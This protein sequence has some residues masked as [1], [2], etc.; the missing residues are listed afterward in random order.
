MKAQIS[1]WMLSVGSIV[2]ICSNLQAGTVT[3][4][5]GTNSFQMEFVTIGNP[6]NAADTTG[7]PNPVGSVGYIYEM[8][9]YEVSE[10]M[11]TKYNAEFG[12]ENS[13]VVTHLNQGPNRPATSITWNEAARF[14]NWLNTSTGGF[15]AYKFGS[16]GVNDAPVLWTVSDLLDYDASNPYRSK[17]TRFVLP[18]SNEWYKAAYFNPS[19]GTY[20]DFPT[21]SNTAPVAVSSGTLANTAVYGQSEFQGS[22]EVDK[23]GGL[24][25]YGV[26]GLGGNVWEWEETSFDLNNNSGSKDRAL[27]GGHWYEGSSYL[28]STFRGNGGGP[29]FSD[30]RVGFRV[31]MVTPSSGEVPEPTSIAIFGLGALGLAYHAR[32]KTKA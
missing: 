24:S 2:G 3:F 8:G 25:P 5:S 16:T 13:L 10:Q 17:R 27:R 4:G 6:G 1:A 22:A 29:F 11:I 30:G 28:S 19:N 21:G 26:M 9:K 23:A 32:R 20:Y 15:A 12:N 7:I 14:I 18:T 31:A